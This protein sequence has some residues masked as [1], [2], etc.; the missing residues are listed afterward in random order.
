M[1]IRTVFCLGLSFAIAIQLRP[2]LMLS[3][4][5]PL[6][7]MVNFWVKSRNSNRFLTHLIAFLFPFL[8]IIG[9]WTYRNYKI[10]H[11]FAPYEYK[12]LDFYVNDNFNESAFVA[13]KEFINSLGYSDIFWDNKNPSSFFED[14]SSRFK[15]TSHFNYPQNWPL[16]DFS[17]LTKTRDYLLKYQKTKSIQDKKRCI[18]A[19]NNLTD[20][21]KNQHPF[22]R[23]IA[24]GQITYRMIIQ[25][26]TYFIPFTTNQGIIVVFWKIFEVLIYILLLSGSFIGTCISI[27]K[28]QYSKYLVLILI[29]ISIVLLTIYNRHAETR[30]FLYSIPSL[31][32]LS[33]FAYTYFKVNNNFILLFLH[34]I[35]NFSQR[36][37]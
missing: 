28:R 14:S 11:I 5:I 4:L 18:K 16:T 2:Y 26:N 1:K 21:L 3:F 35:R 37:K 33:C 34:R 19:F 23:F 24:I 22:Q 30:Y 27:I 9:S 10:Y 17:E 15:L 12:L 20:S 7:F 36:N 6:I 31:T 13:K 8:L 32:I 25:S 29:P